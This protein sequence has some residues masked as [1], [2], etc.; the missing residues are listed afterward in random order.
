MGTKR[1]LLTG[2]GFTHNFGTPLAS[3]MWAEIFNNSRIQ[4]VPKVREL[5]LQDYD[6][7]S[8]YATIME[9]KYN[10]E[11]KNVIKEAVETAY[12]NLD[13]IVRNHP[14][15]GIDKQRL[16]DFINLFVGK[17]NG[18][19]GYFFTLNQDLFIERFSSDT[20]K[21]SFPNF[22]KAEGIFNVRSNEL[23]NECYYYEVPRNVDKGENIFENFFYIKLHGSQNWL[24]SQNERKMIIGKNKREQLSKEPLLDLYLEL[25]EKVLCQNDRYLLIIGYGFRDEHINKIIAKAVKE[26]RLKI[27]IISPEPVTSFYETKINCQKKDVKDIKLNDD[28]TKI[29]EGLSGYYP[30]TLQ[31]IFPSSWPENQEYKNLCKYF[32]NLP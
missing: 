13:E 6:Y 11:E 30:Y 24:D 10:S 26:N 22:E 5:M 25:F 32:F 16:L 20:V 3:G 2:A 12:K 4:A 9:G 14:N 29:W 7:E 18:E 23:K 17:E 27:Y 1:I 19:K 15:V 8:V 31:E 28:L 21:M